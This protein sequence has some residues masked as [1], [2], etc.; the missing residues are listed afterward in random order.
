[1]A[2]RIGR[3]DLGAPVE[4]DIPERTQMLRELGN[5]SYE[6]RQV[7]GDRSLF[8][9]Q[10]KDWHRRFV[11]ALRNPDQRITAVIQQHLHELLQIQTADRTHRMLQPIYRFLIANGVETVPEHLVDPAA[12]RI[13]AELQAGQMAL[14]LLPEPPAPAIN[15]Q[16]L[17]DRVTFLREENAR[18]QRQA[19]EGWQEVQR[20]ALDLQ[21]RLGVLEPRIQVVEQRQAELR[22]QLPRAEADIHRLRQDIAAAK[23]AADQKAKESSGLGNVVGPLVTIAVCFAIYLATSGTAGVVQ[24]F[25][26]P[27]TGGAMAGG[28]FPLPPL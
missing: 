11:F 14:R 4:V 16:P 27:V 26:R 19:D 7:P 20:A 21:Q 2:A 10:L 22:N 5:F 23:D 18:A 9:D 6:L 13:L 12:A 15:L 8:T 24:P 3:A 25:V 1:M 17:R 28:I